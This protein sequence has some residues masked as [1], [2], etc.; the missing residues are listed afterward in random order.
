MVGRDAM[1]PLPAIELFCLAGRMLAPSRSLGQKMS[2][3]PHGARDDR[4][5]PAPAPRRPRAVASGLGRLAFGRDPRNRH[6]EQARPADRG[7]PGARHHHLRSCRRLWRLPRRGTVRR[8]LT[9]MEGP[10]EPHR[11]GDQMRH[12]A[13]RVRAASTSG[14]ALRQQWRP[15]PSLA[16]GIPS[17]PRHRPCR[18]AAA[19]SARPADGR[20]RDGGRPGAAG[21]CRQDQGRRR[22]QPHARPDRPA[23]G[24]PRR[25]RW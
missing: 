11:A 14:Q 6:A 5:P 19:T 24:A 10:A 4:Q 7:L 20:G 23:A 22:F 8:G 9:R 16:G 3:R 25:S 21:S 2:A 15:H 17:A 12:R 18:P 1:M 13:G